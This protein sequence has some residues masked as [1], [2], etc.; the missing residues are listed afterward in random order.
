MEATLMEAA[1][2]EDESL[3]RETLAGSQASFQ[4]LV[5]R[6]QERIFSLARHY[7]RNAVDVED[8]VQDTFLKAFSRLDTFQ[9]QSSFFTWLYRIAV[10]TILDGIKRRGR[11]PVNIVEDPEAVAA[12]GSTR[13][14]GPSAG[15]E[16]D[17]I[18]RITHAV[19]GELPEIFRAVLVMR[20][21]EDLSYQQIA[22]VLGISIGTVESRLF[23]ARAR[24]KDKLLQRHPEFGE[25]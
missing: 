3:V 22:D 9:G 7:T 13:V 24:F 1:Q 2:V 25:E 10:N 17:E 11:S 4:L 12:P 23:R 20:E 14:S 6:Y 21:F 18:A 15:M 19:L 16:R 8:L 5:E